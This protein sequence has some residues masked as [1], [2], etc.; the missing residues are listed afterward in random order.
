MYGPLGPVRRRRRVLG[1]QKKFSSIVVSCELSHEGPNTRYL[2]LVRNGESGPRFPR[3]MAH[4]PPEKPHPYS[5]QRSGHHKTANGARSI[6][7]RNRHCPKCQSLARAAWIEQRQAE[8]LD[9][10]YFH[11]VFTLP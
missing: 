10:S 11:V 3:W 2:E 1:A 4:A 9:C 6:S 7:C 8:L 5:P